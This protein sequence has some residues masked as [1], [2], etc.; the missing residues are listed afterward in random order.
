MLKKSM[1]KKF[2]LMFLCAVLYTGQ[3]GAQESFSVSF[4][5]QVNNYSK[6]F[7][8]VG[9]VLS[10]DFRF[11]EMFSLGTS[12]LLCWD[13]SNTVKPPEIPQ[14]DLSVMELAVNVRWYFLRFA[15]LVDYYF[16][17]QNYLHWFV[18]LD[19]GFSVITVGENTATSY[20]AKIPIMAGL[21]AGVRIIFDNWYIEPYIRGGEPFA[22]ACGF[23][24]GIRITGRD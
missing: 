2:V 4:G 3:L 13:L 10:A 5:L 16:L 12:F 20:W 1:E 6:S 17:W 7:L 14:P 23:L 11:N 15:D 18:Q 8:A 19:L 21:T 22:W 9:G 24:F